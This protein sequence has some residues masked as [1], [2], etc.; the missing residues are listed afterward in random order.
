METNPRYL[1]PSLFSVER[2]LAVF[3]A[4]FPVDTKAQRGS[5]ASLKED[6]LMRANVEVFQ[7]LAE[8]HSLKLVATTVSKNIDFLNYKVKWK[9]NVPWEIVSEVSK[10]VNF[11]VGQYFI[12]DTWFKEMSTI[13]RKIKML[14]LI[15][16]TITNDD[17][18]DDGNDDNNLVSFLKVWFIFK[19]RLL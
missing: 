12:G 11:D 19:I 15:T 2:L 17:G 7:N 5:L 16:T 8:L 4:I 3:Q 10:S 9:V 1:Q 18:N 6:S 13:D 14:T